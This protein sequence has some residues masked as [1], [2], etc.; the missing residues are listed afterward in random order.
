VPVRERGP[1]DPRRPRAHLPGLWPDRGPGS[2]LRAA[3]RPRPAHRPGR[4]RHRAPRCGVGAHHPDLV[5][6]RAT[7]SPVESTA[8]RCPPR[9]G[10]HPHGSPPP[11]GAAGLCST[12]H[13]PPASA[14]PG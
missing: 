11:L 7:R 4:P 12:Q 5:S 8:A 2:G 1:Q 13:H 6:I 9:P 10:T 3:G 14:N